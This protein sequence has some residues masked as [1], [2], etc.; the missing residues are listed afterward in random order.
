MREALSPPFRGML[1]KDGPSSVADAITPRLSC[2]ISQQQE[3]LETS[4]VVTRLQ[5]I[6]AL[7][8]TNKKVA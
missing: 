2:E 6:L 3:L 4:D 8:Q 7:M 1:N 5:K